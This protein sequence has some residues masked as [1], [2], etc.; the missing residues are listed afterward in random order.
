MKAYHGNR[1]SGEDY[2]AVARRGSDKV[3]HYILGGNKVH[4]PPAKKVSAIATKYDNPSMTGENDAKYAAAKRPSTAQ[5]RDGPGYMAS[6]FA[7]T[8]KEPV[9]GAKS[10]TTSVKTISKKGSAVNS[11]EV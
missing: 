7:K 6:T 1:A 10:S 5:V 8:S 9:G 3:F 2:D 4:V 11:E